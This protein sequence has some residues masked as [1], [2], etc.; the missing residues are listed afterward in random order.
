MIVAT[1]VLKVKK[2]K[3][4]YNIGYII[5]NGLVLFLSFWWFAVIRMLMKKKSNNRVIFKFNM[6]LPHHCLYFLY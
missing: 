1:S 4:I 5:I 3:K 2:K 6:Y